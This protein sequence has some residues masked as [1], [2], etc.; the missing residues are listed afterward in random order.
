MS[1]TLDVTS[2]LYSYSGDLISLGDV[3]VL[4]NFGNV[5]GDISITDDD[6]TL[7]P[8]EVTTISIDGSDETATYGHLDF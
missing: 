7:A 6:G 3:A 5:S 8:S 4:P 1:V 2:N